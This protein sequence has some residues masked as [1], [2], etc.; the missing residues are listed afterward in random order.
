MKTS[1]C[2]TQLIKAT[3]LLLLFLVNLS[4]FS[5]QTLAQSAGGTSA[6]PPKLEIEVQP[7][8]VVTKEVKVRND[9]NTEKTVTV[10]IKD[11]AV[12]D[13]LGTPVQLE[14]I[15]QDDNRWAA[16]SWLQIS[17]R[18]VR[19]KAYETK[20]LMLSVLAPNDALPG[21]H[22]AMVLYSPDSSNSIDGT[23]AAIQTNVGSLIYITVPGNIKQDARIDRFTAPKFSEFG[24]I[25]F[26]TIITNL[27]DIHI[28]PLGAIKIT[29][30]LGGKT[31]DLT[32]EDKNV[33]P[34]TTRSF[35]NTLDKK[36]LFGRYKAQF[37]AGY[38]TNG[39]ALAAT[40]YFWVI[41]WRLI[42]LVL[43]V[44]ILLF[45]GIKYLTSRRRPG[46]QSPEIQKL[47]SELEQ[48]KNK[49]KDRS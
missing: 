15:T 36:Y 24:P 49:Y 35:E 25:N 48:L 19:L 40:L 41:P 21:G 17:Q 28:K 46:P 12:F 34:Y 16:A 27:S 18:Q 29:N 37:L 42:L 13:D 32:L 38:G 30:W 23:G 20:S 9:S 5:T 39:G 43:F 3:S 31:A 47:E 45:I 11:F 44:L 2:P 4:L 14:D 1:T 10:T 6:I 8:K 26:S 22:Y 33:F 7:G